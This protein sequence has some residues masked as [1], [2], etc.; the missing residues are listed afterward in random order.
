MSQG[1]HCEQHCAEKKSGRQKA[2]ES[3]EINVKLSVPGQRQA[4]AKRAGE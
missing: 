2:E 4:V 3:F 1:M